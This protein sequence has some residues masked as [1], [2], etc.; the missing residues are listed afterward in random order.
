LEANRLPAGRSTDG[1]RSSSRWI[2]ERRARPVRIRPRASASEEEVSLRSQA[3]DVLARA[4]LTPQQLARYRIVPI[5][6]PLEADRLL[7]RIK[8]ASTKKSD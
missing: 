8:S 5:S 6:G 3:A 1:P 4:K 2:D 7:P